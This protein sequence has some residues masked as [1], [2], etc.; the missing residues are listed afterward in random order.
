MRECAT[1][2]EKNHHSVPRTN[3][4]QPILEGSLGERSE[5]FPYQKTPYQTRIKPVSIPYQ[6]RIKPVSNCI[7]PVS[8]CIRLCPMS[9]CLASTAFKR[10]TSGLGIGLAASEATPIGEETKMPLLGRLGR[11]GCSHRLRKHCRHA[12]HARLHACDRS[13]RPCWDRC[14][15]RRRVL[16]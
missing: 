8:N 16:E 2:C 7:R 10:P 9:E 4:P 11:C 5:T 6:T 3:C 12:C 14:K 1:P 13:E 15:L